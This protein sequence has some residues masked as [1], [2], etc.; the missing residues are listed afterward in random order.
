[1]GQTELMRVVVIR[2]GPDGIMGRRMVDTAALSDAGPWENLGDGG[3]SPAY[4]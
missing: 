2:I 1:M 4:P 3:W